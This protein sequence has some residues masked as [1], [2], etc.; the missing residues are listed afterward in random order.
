MY[1]AL[2]LV[3]VQ[4]L[5]RVNTKFVRK[6]VSVFSLSNLSLVHYRDYSRA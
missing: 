4:I 6:R 1:C 5:I 2:E 3:Y